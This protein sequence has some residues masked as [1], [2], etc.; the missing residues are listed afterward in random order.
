MT[1]IIQI[2]IGVAIAL[3]AIGLLLDR[4]SRVVI[5]AVETPPSVYP[6]IDPHACI[7][8]GNCVDA[9]PETNVLAMVAGRPRLVHPSACVGHSDC[10]RSC[11]ANAIELV[12]GSPDRGVEVPQMSG[13]FETTVPGVYVAGEV[14]GMG[15]IHNAV[16]QGRQA[17]RHALDGAARG[18]ELEL[19]I[20]GGGPAGLGAALEAQHRGARYRV[21]EKRTIG[22][23]VQAYPRRK[24]VMTAPIELP[25]GEKVKLRRT[26]KEALIE[27]F[28]Q[29]VRDH[30]LAITEQAEV[31][32]ITRTAQGFAIETA[33]GTV[34]A[35]RVVLAIGRR[36]MPR[37]LAAPGIELPHVIYDLIDPE[38]FAGSAVV[39]VGGGDSAVE[40]ALALAR[41]GAR[42]TLVH[43][44][45]DFG[46]CKPDNRRA[47]EL[48]HAR[49]E[50]VI[51]TRANVARVTP[52]QVVLADGQALAATRVVCALGAELPTEWLRSIGIELREMRGEP[53]AAA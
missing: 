39:V 28:E 33:A 47:L 14:T 30:E 40:A 15:L 27:L 16:R 45:A 36:G 44:G 51:I 38:T 1:P 19:A 37:R 11:P 26:S 8:S 35:A 49:Q 6:R 41:A 18:A 5:A 9:C 43:R 17:A 52:D 32:A 7:C 12:L 20:V 24:I 22:G 48:A 3:F 29:L 4:R 10:L 42:A 34:T 46:R 21:F 53:L 13:R 23:A 25:G 31:R 50:L 2:G